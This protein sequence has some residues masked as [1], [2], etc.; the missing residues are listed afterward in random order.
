MI[1]RDKDGL[2]LTKDI[3]FNENGIMIVDNIEMEEIVELQNLV[4]FLKEKRHL[5]NNSRLFLQKKRYSSKSAAPIH[6]ISFD[7]ALDLILNQK[8]ETSQTRF[9]IDK[10]YSRDEIGGTLFADFRKDENEINFQ[11]WQIYHINNEYIEIPTHFIHGIYNTDEEYFKH[12]DGALISHNKE[13]RDK[14]EQ[15]IIP[16]KD[17]DN[18]MKLFR[19]DGIITNEEAK[20]MMSIY[21]P[22]EE[23]NQ[24]FL[25]IN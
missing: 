2:I 13:Y 25:E 9:R 21:L 20:E 17:S 19:L 4:S 22:I 16:P 24:E 3:L 11:L 10:E 8:K 15:G 14:I 23:L 5:W 12:F 6:Y 7:Q 18:Y 1:K